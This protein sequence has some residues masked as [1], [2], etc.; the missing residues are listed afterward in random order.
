LAL[1]VVSIGYSWA[2]TACGAANSA[3]TETC[4]RCGSNAITSAFEIETGTNTQRGPK[5][6]LAATSLVI[7]AGGALVMGSTLLWIFNPPDTAWW[8]GLGLFIA[9]FVLAGVAKLI[10]GGK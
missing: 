5:L 1:G 4:R 7:L 9:I 10:G 3:D 8:V 2:C 6:S